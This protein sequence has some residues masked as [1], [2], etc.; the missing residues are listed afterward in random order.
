MKMKRLLCLMAALLLLTG[1]TAAPKTIAAVTLPPVADPYTP[2]VGDA[3][4]SGERL[5]VLYLPSADGQRLLTYYT[6]VTMSAAQHPAEAVLRALLAFE[7]NDRVQ[8]LGGGVTLALT[9]SDPVEL[10]GSVCTVNLSASALQLSHQDFYTA[11]LSIA[12][13]LC[14]LQGVSHVN[15]L[16]AG[17][18]AAMDV[19]GYLPLGT[20][21]APAS[22]ELTLQWEQL[23]ARRTPVGEN[24][25]QMPLYADATLYFP[26]ED[27]AGVA[28]EARS[29]AF[30]GQ[31]PQQ[32]VLTLLSALADGADALPGA[33]QMPDFA[34]MML[35]SPAVSDLESGGKRVTL[36]FSA[37]VKNRITAMG[38]DPACCFAAMV[39]TLTTFIP[40]L[41]QVCILT[42][43]SALTSLYNTRWGTLLFPGGLHRRT[44]YAAFLMGQSTLYA[45]QDSRLT[46]QTAALPYRSARDPRALLLSLAA[47]GT[48]PRDL[49]DADILG[50]GIQ[51]DTLL[52]NFSQR[53]AGVIR[54]S[55][56]DQR[57][58]A[59]ALTETLIE[60]LNVKRVRIYFGSEPVSDLGQALRWDG[61]FLH[62]PG[63]TGG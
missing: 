38:L 30:P 14:E 37:G 23:T 6:P 41:Q 2:P 21:S 7:G 47:R 36:H 45:A 51:G 1:C 29:L 43:D 5:A 52:V 48:L 32:L 28:A 54:D 3:G 42:G 35:A 8:S 13:T 34:S 10:S 15:V 19:G 12:A 33:A 24:P 39:Q 53:Y 40:G 22:H 46:A 57:L 50:L 25:S 4:L 27:G 44:D 61:E 9:G 56:L 17:Q 62:N 16:V 55:G 59:Y 31:H 11:C 58:M 60:A 49:G 18:S 26:L 20:L 63:L